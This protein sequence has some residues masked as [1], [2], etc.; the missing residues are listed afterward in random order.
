MAAVAG[1][2]QVIFVDVRLV[3]ARAGRDGVAA[4]EAAILELS[5]TV[6]PAVL[7]FACDA[8]G[9][10][11]LRALLA[12]LG[13]LKVPSGQHGGSHAVGRRGRTKGRGAG[14]GAGSGG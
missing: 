11:P 5:E 8:S 2:R 13:G 9:T 10:H 6:A 7:D 12:V 14:G 3:A 1:G 4:L